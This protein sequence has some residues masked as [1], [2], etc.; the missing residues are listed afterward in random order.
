MLAAAL[1][2]GGYY[3]IRAERPE[4]IPTGKFDIIA[5]VSAQPLVQTDKGRTVLTLDDVYLD[6]EA[7]DYGVRL[8]IYS[9]KI[10]YKYGDTLAISATKLSVPDATTNPDGFDF[11]AYL[12]MNG[13][14][15]TGSSTDDKIEIISGAASLKRMLYELRDS[16]AEVSDNIFGD[17]S[18]VMR[19]ILL[20]DRSLLSDDT[21]ED[22]RQTGIAHIIALSGLHVSCIALFIEWCLKRIHLPPVVRAAIIIPFLVLYTV[23]TGASPSTVRAALMYGLLLVTVAAGYPPDTLTRLALAFLIQV[24]YNPLIIGSTGFVLSYATVFGMICINDIAVDIFGKPE[25]R[26]LSRFG[27]VG[28]VSLSAQLATFPLIAGQ[29]YSIPLLSVPVNVLCVPFAVLTLYAGFLLLP[30]GLLWESMAGVLAYP[31]RWIWIG[32]KFITARLSELTLAT[33]SVKAWPFAL[34]LVFFVLIWLMSPYMSGNIKRRRI[35]FGMLPLIIIAVLLWPNWANDELKIT[36]IDVGYGDGALIEA[37]GRTYAVDCGRDNGIAADYITSQGF[38]LSGIFVTHPDSDHAGGLAEM[39]ERNSYAK[40]YLPYCWDELDVSES[41]REA[42]STREVEYLYA[43]CDVVL[44]PDITAEV[45]WPP[46]DFSPPDDNNGSLVIRI[47]YGESSALFMADITDDYDALACAEADVLKV[48][49]HGS[50]YATTSEMLEIVRPSA[51]V[52]SVSSNGFGHPTA[53]VLERLAEVGAEV[54]RTDT[55]GAVTVL[56]HSNGEFEVYPYLDAEAKE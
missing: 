11:N 12:W 50:K 14:A 48:A 29:F 52:I 1:L 19:A 13:V 9:S 34:A 47:S 7:F 51:A 46:E 37:Q 23:M 44:S 36:F 30:L 49:H 21:Y 5:T 18:D 28:L 43:G 35:L 16:L 22:F 24:L 25:N 38:Q 4:D 27:E 6:G 17:E 40:V 33:L 10:E 20:G 39:L 53:E 31:V 32:I 42:L 2:A 15:L 54:Y 55:D 56:M 3:E 8:Y 45:L 26:I 41:L